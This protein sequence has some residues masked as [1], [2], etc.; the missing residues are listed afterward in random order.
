MISVSLENVSIWDNHHGWRHTTP[1]E[2][3]KSYPFGT[4]ANDAIFLCESCG[5]YAL[6]AVGDKQIPHFRHPGGSKDCKDKMT[7]RSNYYQTNRLGF[8]LPLKIQIDGSKL[9]VF[10]G[11]LPISVQQMKD[12]VNNGAIVKILGNR[13][14]LATFLI[15]E[16]RFSSDHIT[17]IS[18][19]NA[20][21]EKYR[22]SLFHSSTS[23][24]NI[25]PQVVNGFDSGGT[26]FDPDTGKRLPVNA[27][28]EVHRKYYL[29]TRKHLL[30]DSFDVDKKRVCCLDNGWMLYE[31][32]ATK[33]SKNAATF[34]LQF[35]SRLTDSPAYLNLVWPP[36]LRTS[37][38]ITYEQG[39]VVFYHRGGGCVEVWPS[40][41]VNHSNDGTSEGTIQ[42]FNSD[43]VQQ[44]LSLS[45]FAGRT[46]VLRY[47]VLHMKELSPA[48]QQRDAFVTDVEGN[49]IAQ[50][51]YSELPP[52]KCLKARTH[53]DGYVEVK[54][55]DWVVAK[56][57]I[58]GGE[59]AVIPVQ[60]NCT[61]AVYQGRDLVCRVGYQ[62]R[63]SEKAD[64]EELLKH[65]TQYRSNMVKVHH[66]LG[67]IAAKL[68][69]YP[70]TQRW[71]AKQIHRGTIS[72]DAIEEIKRF[73]ISNR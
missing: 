61:V 19:G 70:E 64:A 20:V 67:R 28:V 5:Q 3:I 36:G 31:V 9:A 34:F 4:A 50:G 38:V 53:F 42:S 10:I 39:P 24:A 63:P 56:I 37:H 8:S 66:N 2:A 22:L 44:V 58:S 54:N 72:Q 16:D 14:E 11:F 73:I 40:T 6:L 46:S 29:I 57:K 41:R 25:W 45:R 1:N 59:F 62:R 26:L 30:S 68:T 69:A 55:G 15:N 23:I 48:K 13:Q 60:W 32:S 12:S 43:A 21:C 49:W 71:L 35:G 7:A 51:E 18:V 47:I 27:D 52:E 65:L 33:L 17:Y